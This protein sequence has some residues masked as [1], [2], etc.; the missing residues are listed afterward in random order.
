MTPKGKCCTKHTTLTN[1]VV[2]GLV[3][4]R[5]VE[6]TN[7]SLNLP[8]RIQCDPTPAHTLDQGF[9]KHDTWAKCDPVNPRKRP[10]ISAHLRQRINK[11]MV[12]ASILS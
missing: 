3:H 7:N 8:T 2:F 1:S 9:S 4:I 10:A 6:N 5:W 12:T 11:F